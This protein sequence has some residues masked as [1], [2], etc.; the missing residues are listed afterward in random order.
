MTPSTVALKSHNVIQT[1]IWWCH[2]PN[3]FY[4]HIEKRPLAGGHVERE[5]CDW[6]LSVT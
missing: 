4:F 5:H 3:V 1:D 6:S 2:F